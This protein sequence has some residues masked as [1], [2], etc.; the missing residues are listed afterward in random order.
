MMLLSSSKSFIGSVPGQDT[1]YI[2]F[3]SLFPAPFPGP[4]FPL[5]TVQCH[6]PSYPILLQR[7][8]ILG[9]TIL[10]DPLTSGGLPY[11][12]TILYDSVNYVL[13]R[14]DV[15]VLL[16]L[17]TLH[18]MEFRDHFLPVPLVCGIIL[19]H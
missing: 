9:G 5:P 2:L 18:S 3:H 13:F 6:Y 10:G 4:S 19:A 16:F 8:G 14:K 12:L 15:F 7:R 17:E 1:I 11:T